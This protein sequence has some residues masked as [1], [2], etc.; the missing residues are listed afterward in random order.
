MVTFILMTKCHKEPSTQRICLGWGREDRAC[1]AEGTQVWTL[2]RAPRSEQ[3][4]CVLVRG[5]Q[6][7]PGI[8]W[9]KRRQ[10]YDEA[11]QVGRARSCGTLDQ[12]KAFGLY[13]QWAVILPIWCSKQRV[14]RAGVYF[15]KITL[16]P[17][18]PKELPAMT[19]VI[20]LSRLPNAISHWPHVTNEHLRCGECNWRIF[21]FSLF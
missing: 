3:V 1:H 4:L 16:S 19:E 21:I 11:G 6:S 7:M 20:L 15:G 10:K 18:Y 8:W 13:S 12:N 5:S 9:S 14:S 2:M 17:S